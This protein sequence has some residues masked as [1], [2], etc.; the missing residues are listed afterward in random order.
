MHREFIES[1]RCPYTGSSLA[2]QAVLRED[3]TGVRYGIVASEAGEFPIVEGILR[4]PVDELREPI[5]AL[6]RQERFREALLTA[7]EIPFNGKAGAAINLVSR[8]AYRAGFD[9]IAKGASLL[10][11]R[12]YGVFTRNGVTLADTLRR[13]RDGS[14]INSQMYRFSMRTFLSVYPLLHVVQTHRGVLDLGCGL[15]H[16]AFL[17]SKMHPGTPITCADYS[18]TALFLGQ[19][20]LLSDA[21]FVCLDGNHLLPFGT[22]HFSTV[23][24]SDALHFIDGKRSLSREMIRAIGEDGV[25]VLP[26]LH[27]GLSPIRYAKS[28]TPSGYDKL[29]E[30]HERR[31]MPE[32]TVVRQFLCEDQLDLRREWSSGELA[33]DTT[34][35]SIVVNPSNSVF[36][37]YEGLW[38]RYIRRM[39]NPVVNPIYKVDS[40]NETV[41]RKRNISEHYGAELRFNGTTY[42][43]NVYRLEQ[44][45]DSPGSVTSIRQRRPDVFHELA[46]KFV[47]IDVP[48]RFL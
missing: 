37:R 20:Y 13:F 15:G 43:P 34:G 45:I 8:M 10:K 21:E 11:R 39:T 26:H 19:K 35:I 29:F 4:L 46:N 2:L 3:D 6:V 44:S 31:V 9:T 17:I 7:L 40:K 12:M 41:L 32:S 1:L 30:G 16:G 33:K 47:M 42:V 18:F 14:W 5:A 22:R 38:E 36:R 28:L 27:N 24:S 25:L 48:E 23:F